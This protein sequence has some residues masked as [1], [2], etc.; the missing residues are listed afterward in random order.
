MKHKPI[1]IDWDELED[2]FNEQRDDLVS[3]LDLVTGHV[4]LEGEGEDDEDLD[5][6]NYDTPVRAPVAPP[7]PVDDSTRL[8]VTPPGTTLKVDWLKEFIGKGDVPGEVSGE[9]SEAMGAE[10]PAPEIRAVLNRNPEVRDSW[11]RYRGERI[12][13]L[14]DEWLAANGVEF[15]DPPPWR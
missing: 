13:A 3:Y 1:K 11:Y 6:E 5:D 10:D 4:V 8:H 15:T 9:L 2:A 7:P 12:Q 14:I